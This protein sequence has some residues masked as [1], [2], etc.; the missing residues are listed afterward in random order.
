MT[1]REFHLVTADAGP[2]TVA[3]GV[4][5][6]RPVGGGTASWACHVGFPPSTIF[7]FTPP[8]RMGIRNLFEFQTLMYR[9]LYWLGRRGQPGVDYDLSLADPPEWSDDGR[10]V[11][12]TL[13]PW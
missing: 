10:S 8:E 4:D 12:V 1:K 7:P 3:A 11:T 13:K 5:S 2:S 6:A 9:P